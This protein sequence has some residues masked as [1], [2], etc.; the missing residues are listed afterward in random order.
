MALLLRPIVLF[1]LLFI[2]FPDFVFSGDADAL[3]A[4]KSALDAHDRLPWRRDTSS[5]LCTRWPGVKQ[6]SGDGRVLK[7]VLEFLDLN[8]ILAAGLLSPLDQIRVLSFKSNSLSGDIP[9]LSVLPNLKSVYLNENRFSG[10]IPASISS[11]HRLK[12]VVLAGNQLSGHIP[13]AITTLP[14]LYSLQLQ[15]NRLIGTIPPLNQSTLRVLNLTGNNLSGEIPITRALSQ[16]NSSSFLNNPKLCGAQIGRP[17]SENGK[18]IFLGGVAGLYSLEDLLKASAETL[19]RGTAGST[20]KA[21]MD[22]GFI[23]TVKRL[24]EPAAGPSTAEEFRR[25]MEEVGRLRHPNLV[26]LRAYFQAK[27]ERLLVYDYFPNG[28]LFSLI[29][30]NGSHPTGAGKPLHW[31]SCLKIAEDVATGLLYLHQAGEVHRNLKSSNVLLGPDFESCLTDF[32]LLPAPECRLPRPSSFTPPSDI[33]SFGILLLELLTGKTPVHDLVDHHI[34]D[35]PSWVRAAREDEKEASASADDPSASSASVGTQTTAES[36]L[37][38]LLAISTACLAAAAET[39]PTATEVVRMIREA[40][41]EGVASVSS[42]SSGRVV[43]D[44]SG[45]SPGRWSDAV[46]SLPREYGSEHLSFAERD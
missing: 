3:L 42:N 7:L 27:E 19:G 30:G 36:K 11:I 37:A 9:D 43:E 15:N 1:P 28:S 24:R 40:R 34:A 31:T 25:R 22:T 29:H 18:L 44:N 35:I 38:A 10:R 20:Y 23:V 21:V 45:H 39:R 2:F 12:T 16:F 4:L 41:A 32:C 5:E 17:C 33:Y 6:C 14:R 46:Q 8:G 13:P 26:P